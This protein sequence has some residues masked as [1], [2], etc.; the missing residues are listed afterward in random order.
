MIAVTGGAGFIGS[1]VVD[2]LIAA[3]HE[4]SIVDILST[5]NR[6]NV[7]PA[8]T[9]YEADIRSPELAEIFDAA[10]PEIVDHH[11]AHAEVR[12]S[13]EDPVYDAWLEAAQAA[14]MPVTDDYNGKQQEGFG[15]GQ[16]TIRNG[17]R[18][19]AATA[20]LKPARSRRNLA[21]ETGAHA[22]RILMRGT[23]A[24]GV[25]FVTASGG[26]DQRF[27]RQRQISP[28]TCA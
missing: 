22:T 7:N 4:V 23:R 26:V 16:Y 5:G 28:G 2:G 9:F 19:S 25:E 3:G 1:H 17:Y 10:R 27:L 21:V 11:A 13:V 15:R 8:A 20:Y 24:T 18:S 6:R 12:E 14:G